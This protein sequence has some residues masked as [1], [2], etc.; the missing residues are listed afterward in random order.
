MG[1]FCSK[2][3]ED[4]IPVGTAKGS[5]SRVVN[6]TGSCI[7]SSSFQAWKAKQQFV[8]MTFAG[9]WGGRLYLVSLTSKKNLKC[10]GNSPEVRGVTVKTGPKRSLGEQEMVETERHS[11]LSLPF[12]HIDRMGRIQRRRHKLSWMEAA[13]FLQ[14]RKSAEV[15]CLILSIRKPRDPSCRRWNVEMVVQWKIKR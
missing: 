3:T 10:N 5:G 13:Q 8:W 7:A 1:D 12:I 4:C 14:S 9:G 15:F 11:W 2:V 6:H